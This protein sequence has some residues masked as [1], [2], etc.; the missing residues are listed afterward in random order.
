MLKI[1]DLMHI[2]PA[3]LQISL[4]T[5][6]GL[7]AMA[8]SAPKPAEPSAG[9]SPRGLYLTQHAPKPLPSKT[10]LASFAAGCFWGVEQEFRKT[11]GVIATAVGYTGGH[12]PNP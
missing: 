10:E 3:M 12:T 9:K 1:K 4:L 11:E 5:L 8:F 6:F 2:R 7:A